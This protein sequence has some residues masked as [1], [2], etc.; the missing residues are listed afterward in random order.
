MHNE[1]QPAQERNAQT[2][3]AA[4]YL[5]DSKRRLFLAAREGQPLPTLKTPCNQQLA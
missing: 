5:L 2:K 3:K 4:C 1:Q